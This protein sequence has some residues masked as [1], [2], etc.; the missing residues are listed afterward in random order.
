MNAD[1]G[2]GP[3]YH[4]FI[5]RDS[6]YLRIDI[7]PAYHPDV[8]ADVQNLPFNDKVFDFVL[9]DNVV[10]HV[11]KPNNALKELKRVSKEILIIVPKWYHHTAWYMGIG[12]I[13]GM[14]RF[15]YFRKSFVK[16][17][18]PLRILHLYWATWSSYHGLGK[19]LQKIFRGN[20][21]I[22]FETIK[23]K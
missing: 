21:K 14:H 18:F 16:I 19:F 3:F 11:E 6:N 17:P 12:G 23:C 4:N 5:M 7:E 9:C 22:F 20:N 10:E 13:G 2:C 8:V 1:V 15:I